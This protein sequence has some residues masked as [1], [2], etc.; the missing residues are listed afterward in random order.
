[1]PYVKYRPANSR[2]AKRS[3]RRRMVRALAFVITVLTAAWLYTAFIDNATGV[4]LTFTS[5]ARGDDLQVVV[6]RAW[7]ELRNSN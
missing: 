4:S 5:Q 2:A 1:M 6:K 7:D 3:R